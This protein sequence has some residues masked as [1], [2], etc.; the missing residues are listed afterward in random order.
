MIHESCLKPATP[1]KGT[2]EVD[3][4]QAR[5]ERLDI[6]EKYERRGAPFYM[7]GQ[8]LDYCT[9]QLITH[10]N[11]TLCFFNELIIIIQATVCIY[12]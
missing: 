10:L 11:F 4:G 6:Q 7:D 2:V 8:V 5:R 12:I 9:V 1:E 3:L